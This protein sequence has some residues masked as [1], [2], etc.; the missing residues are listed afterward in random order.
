MRIILFHYRWTTR[1]SHGIYR[2]RSLYRGR[3][4]PPTAGGKP[5]SWLSAWTINNKITTWKH[6]F[7]IRAKMIHEV[8]ISTKRK[9]SYDVSN[10][11]R[12]WRH[13]RN[14]ELSRA[15]YESLRTASRRFLMIFRVAASRLNVADDFQIWMYSLPGLV[16]WLYTKAP[17]QLF[18]HQLWEEI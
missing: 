18:I 17:A 7:E 9:I 15:W 8:K 3:F 11:I 13:V 5:H 1:C 2:Y 12:L 16:Y 6:K 14:V 10:W 4:Y